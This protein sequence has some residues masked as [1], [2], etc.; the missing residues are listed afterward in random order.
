MGLVARAEPNA[1]Q[2]KMYGQ[3]SKLSNAQFDEHFAEDMVKDHKLEFLAAG[4]GGPRDCNINITAINGSV[5]MPAANILVRSKCKGC[6][7]N[8]II[9]EAPFRCGI[10]ELNVAPLRTITG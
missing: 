3:V 10:F 5:F 1:K 7:G 4:R 9:E 8:K 6:S 2:K